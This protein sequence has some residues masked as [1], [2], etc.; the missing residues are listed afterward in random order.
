MKSVQN[1]ISYKSIVSI[2]SFV[3]GFTIL[4]VLLLFLGEQTHPFLADL[5]SLRSEYMIGEQLSKFYLFII[6][7]SSIH[8]YQ[9]VKHPEEIRTSIA[10][11]MMSLIIYLSESNMIVESAQ[12]LFGLIL[13]I[14]LSRTLLISRAWLSLT[15][16]VMGFAFFCCGAIAD[17]LNDQGSWVDQIPVWVV[18]FVSPLSEERLELN[19]IVCLCLAT[20]LHFRVYLITLLFSFPGKVAML[21][22]AVLALT[23]GNGFLHHGYHPEGLFQLA[24][25]LYTLGGFLGIL[26]I[27]NELTKNGIGF[28]LISREVFISF[29]F[30]FFLLLPS[31]H[32]QNQLSVSLLVWLPFFVLFAHALWRHHPTNS[33]EEESTIIGV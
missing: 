16:I 31:S 3:A 25:L 2:V 21:M 27:N 14:A 22:I 23:F 15:L 12:I 13:F 28:T 29:L 33:F 1:K 20:L 7:L 6:V 18:T 11:L 5:V 32:G 19:G 4:H 24:G 26:A 10:F 8:S 9:V 17:H 30:V